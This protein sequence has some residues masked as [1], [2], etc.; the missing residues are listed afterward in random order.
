MRRCGAFSRRRRGWGCGRRA[1]SI[2]IARARSSVIPPTRRSR[3]RRRSARSRSCATAPTSFR[4]PGSTRAARILSVTYAHRAD[5]GAGVTFECGA[6]QDIS[7]ASSGV[8]GRG[9]Q[10]PDFYHLFAIADSADVDPGELV[11][12]AQLDRDDRR[13]SALVRRFHRGAAAARREHPIVIAFGNPYFLQQIPDASAYVV[14]WGGFPV[15]QSAAARALLGTIPMTANFRSRFPGLDI[16]RNPRLNH[17]M[18]PRDPPPAL[19]PGASRPRS[20]S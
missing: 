4:S 8:R 9:R 2:S 6:A 14:A 11:R 20:T 7:G 5:L 19:R 13:R 16:S 15:S 12:R 1:S 17:G 3:A 10:R 18:P